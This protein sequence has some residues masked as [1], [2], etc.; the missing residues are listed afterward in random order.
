MFRYHS[1]SPPVPDSPTFGECTLCLVTP[2]SAPASSSQGLTGYLR[3]PEVLEIPREYQVLRYPT[4]GGTLPRR[5]LRCLVTGGSAPPGSQRATVPRFPRSARPSVLLQARRR[6]PWHR[7][8]PSR[9][10]DALLLSCEAGR[11]LHIVLLIHSF[12]QQVPFWQWLLN[13]FAT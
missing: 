13:P 12:L 6:T 1:P 2:T 5:M 3:Y 4:E 9:R 10:P 11:H 7:F 8:P